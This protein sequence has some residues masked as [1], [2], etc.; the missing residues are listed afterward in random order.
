MKKGKKQTKMIL[1]MFIVIVIVLV[2][3]N[4]CKN[5]KVSIESS[6]ANQINRVVLNE[7]NCNSTTENN[8]TKIEKYNGNADTIIINENIISG[9][10]LKIDSEAF[11]ECSNLS[12][13]LIDKKLIIEE[14]KLENYEINNN[15]YDEQYVLYSNTQEYSEAYKKY[16]QLSEE[17]KNNLAI[18]P[19]KYDIPMSVIY[20]QSMEENYNLTEIEEIEIPESFDLRDKINI[21]VENQGSS[22]IC[23]TFASLTSVETNLALKHNDYVDLS[24]SHLATF[25]YGLKGGSFVH[26][27]H[28]YYRERIGPVYQDEWPSEM[29][30]P[31][32]RYVEKTVSLPT[33][34]KINAYTQEELNT[35]RK[36][37]KKHIMEYGSLYASIA[38]NMVKNDDNLYV[39][40]TKFSDLPDHAV[41]IIGWDDNF[42][43]ENF[44]INLKPNKDGA[45]LALN[46][47]GESWGDN[48]CFW[49]SY[50]DC[51]VESA[52]KGTISV[53]TCQENMKIQNVIITDKSDNKEIS[54]K[55]D[56]GTN[57]QIEIN[58]NINEI[59]N[60]NQFT[61]DFI[62]PKGENITNKIKVL[63]NQIE[64]K[65]SKILLELD[66]SELDT[67]EYIINVRYEDE[68][69]SIPIRIKIDTFDF[70]IKEDGTI[71]IT[72]FY[73]ND[74]KII[75]PDEFLGYTVTGIEK[76]AFINNNLESITIYDNIKQIGENIVDSSVIIYGKTGSYVEQY[77]AENGY[78]FIDVNKKIIEGQGWYFDGEDDKLYILENTTAKE[79]DYLKKVIKKVDVKNSAKEI[80]GAQFKEY[81]QLE[82]VTLPNTITTIGPQAFSK[83]YNLEAINLPTNITKIEWKTFEECESLKNISIPEEVTTIGNAAFSG[84]ISLQNI[85]IPSG[86]K[87]ISDSTFYK[88]SSLESVDIPKG[89]TS[90]ESS[91]F[92][93]CINL[94]KI[95]IP[96][97][98]NYLGDMAFYQCTSL[99]E[100]DIPL[101][102]N[103][104]GGNAFYG[105]ILNNVIQVGTSEI[106]LPNII[107]KAVSSGDI[108]NCGSGISILNGKLNTST[109]KLEITPRH[110][111]IVISI[112]SGK[113]NGLK[114]SIIVSGEIEYSTY[115]WTSEPVKASLCIGKGE[116]VV[117]NN[118]E[119][120]YKFLE[121]GEFE[122][123]Y[124][125]IKGE[126]KKVTA[127]VENIDKKLPE[128]TTKSNKNEQGFIENI[129]A[130]IS[131]EQSGV[132]S[133][134]SIGYAW[135]TSN[136]IKPTNWKMVDL[137][138]FNDG[139]QK[140][141]FE[142]DVNGLA[143]KYYLWIYKNAFYDMASNGFEKVTDLVSNEPYYLGTEPILQS[144]QIAEPPTTTRYVE[145]ENFKVDGMKVV[146][147]YHNGSSKEITEYEVVDGQNLSIEKSF[148]T[149]S[150]TEN[151]ITEVVT[152]KIEVKATEIQ[153]NAEKYNI[154]MKEA[155]ISNIQPGTT[156]QEIKTHIK[157]NAAEVKILNK[158][159]QEL[160]CEEIVGTGMT[161]QLK[162]KDKIQN[163]I[164]VV[165]GDINCDAK[166]TLS[167]M[168]SLNKHR[169]NKTKLQ[170]INAMA[171]NVNDDQVVDFK[172][173]IKINKYR[174]NKIKEL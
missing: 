37:I 173:L 136:T 11:L 169:L 146:A 13:I 20:T 82:E 18:I 167:D 132:W 148:V 61:I 90:I 131:D 28:K 164:L 92:L 147:M 75:I 142:I 88:C 161:L 133:K 102:L 116:K 101:S 105:C 125:N 83:C 159:S 39:L 57:A 163:M 48:G 19:D 60:N 1:I 140:V 111:E 120:V 8:I 70:K 143:G 127:K 153:I 81:E 151:E 59:L 123:E 14:I 78:I 160:T 145:G 51:W 30:I 2:L 32:K 67:G 71:N 40:N 97:G 50:E 128:I 98:L 54:Y 58:V 17:E 170:K 6:N 122:F 119:T 150:Y 174:L 139:T 158:N 66:T 107:K 144:I 63:G 45:Y 5:T 121:N 22:E 47:W 155:Y 103:S 76:N 171:A 84:C 36:M 166:V 149:I 4:I 73:D 52:L 55:I 31:A 109:N 77:A 99:N 16:L 172:D 95:N 10:S 94:Q 64:D 80:F 79:Y 89:L 114:L 91:A 110:G 72:G 115:E 15:Y 126:N 27:D 113:L 117:N 12:N 96:E 130:E 44:P 85:K 106:E 65:K 53:D 118:G 23:Y 154:N 129:T 165:R 100:F 74:K 135:S 137:P 156:I 21:E 152:Q 138:V 25:S 62:S 24:E 9:D 49:I 124:I 43:K 162:L 104:I 29:G 42:S 93:Y 157:T 108:L 7:S 34:N 112:T 87:V 35:A 86:V 41:S 3:Y 26:A 141:L 134:T 69:M 46:S 38:S 33:I 168:V 68:I 56:K